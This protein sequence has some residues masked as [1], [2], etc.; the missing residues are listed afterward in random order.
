MADGVASHANSRWETAR[1]TA[2]DGA[3]LDGWL[4]TPANPNGG[5]VIVLHGVADTRQGIMEHAS[6][7]LQAGYTVLTPDARGHGAS[8]GDFIT[9]GIREASDVRTWTDWLF[10]KRP[11]RRLYGLGE[12]MGAAIL[13]QSLPREP[14]FRAVV[15]ECPF[16]SFEEVAY[17]R[18]HQLS[19]LPHAAAWPIVKIGIFYTRLRRGVDLHQASPLAALTQAST[20]VL[21]IHGARDENIP[22]RHSRELHAA[23]PRNTELWEVPGAEHVNSLSVAPEIYMRTVEDWFRSH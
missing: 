1:V 2:A 9:Y 15:A 21:L 12:S 16:A 7:L 3:V 13:L 6:F 5:G 18:L 19:G 23:S 11:V 17:D 8:G 14:R 10:A 20:P 4:F 22:I